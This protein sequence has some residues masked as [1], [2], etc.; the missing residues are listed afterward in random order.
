MCT[1]LITLLAFQLGFMAGAVVT[2]E[3]RFLFD[4]LANVF[5][6]STYSAV[7]ESDLEPNFTAD[8]IPIFKNNIYRAPPLHPEKVKYEVTTNLC[9]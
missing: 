8:R 5:G 6:L 1:N 4:W 7:Q 9:L 2:Y 3:L